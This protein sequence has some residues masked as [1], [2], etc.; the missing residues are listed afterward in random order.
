MLGGRIEWE[1]PINFGSDPE[2]NS[3]LLEPHNDIP[4]LPT[5]AHRK[6]LLAFFTLLH[7]LLFSSINLAAFNHI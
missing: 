7:D 1:A 4:S 2:H 5:V 3:A 6:G